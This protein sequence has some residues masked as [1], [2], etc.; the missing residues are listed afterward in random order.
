MGGRKKKTIKSSMSHCTTPNSVVPPAPA[1]T[2]RFLQ[3]NRMRVGTNA[4]P[5]SGGKCGG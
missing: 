5:V 4:H 2:K 3:K 1:P